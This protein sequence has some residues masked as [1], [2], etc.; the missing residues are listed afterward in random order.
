MRNEIVML[1]GAICTVCHAQLSQ[2]TI[3]AMTWGAK[4]KVTF[5]VVDSVGCSVSN[6]AMRV[7]WTCDYKN[8]SKVL[9]TKTDE[10]GIVVIEE[11]S[12]GTFTYF[13]EKDGYYKSEG[14]HSFYVRGETRVKD[15]RWEPWNPTVK[16]VL[17][18]KRKPTPMFCGIQKG[19]FPIPRNTPVGFDFEKGEPVN[20][21][22]NGEYPD[23]TL[24][25]SSNAPLKFSP[26]RTNSLEIFTVDAD[27]GFIKKTCDAQ[28][29]FKSIYECPE[30]G[31][32]RNWVFSF[33]YAYTKVDN[34]RFP[35]GEYLM[36]RTRARHD[37]N[38]NLVGSRYGKIYSLSFDDDPDNPGKGFVSLDYRFNPTENDR[39]LEWNGENVTT[40]E[41]MRNF[42]P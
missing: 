18:E 28:S 34:K 32:V 13:L 31:Y 2:D 39:N 4:T 37:G 9:R 38:G 7:V 3:D 14:K 35:S 29:S 36:F 16:V 10:N 33:A 20:P 17:K 26:A 19:G 42:Q 24:L 6:A 23:V 41:K 1:L 30:T 8:Q 12:R 25:F 15:G 21:Y 11:K 5:H 27:E 40:G 22:G